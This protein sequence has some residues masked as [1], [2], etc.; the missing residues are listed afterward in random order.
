MVIDFTYAFFKQV[1]FYVACFLYSY[2]ISLLH[3]SN[4]NSKKLIIKFQSLL[5]ITGGKDD[6]KNQQK[7]LQ[8]SSLL[9]FI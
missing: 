1:T 4:N 8:G 9:S 7:T 5:A 2:F 6:T 3:I